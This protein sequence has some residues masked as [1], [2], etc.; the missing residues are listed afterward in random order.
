MLSG[1]KIA[2]GVLGA[3]LIASGAVVAPAQAAPGDD[4]YAGSRQLVKTI[5]CPVRDPWPGPDLRT[6]IDVW[7]NIDHPS[8]GLPAPAIALIGNTHRMQITM[9]PITEYTMW[10]RVPWRNLDN[11]RHGVVKVRARAPRNTWQVVLHPGKGR[12]KFEIHQT[13]EAM[14]IVPGV[15]PQTSVCRGSA[16]AV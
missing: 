5:Q 6:W 13:V 16:R 15:N 3:G 10:I 2:L 1:V 12:V 14:F 4:P 7:N 8:D 11:G 9:T